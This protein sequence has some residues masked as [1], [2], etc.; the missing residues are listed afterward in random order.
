M[1]GADIGAG[2][3]SEAQGQALIALAR[4]TISR[5]LGRLVPAAVDPLLAAPALQVQSGT[6]VTLKLHGQLRGCIGSLLATGSIVE[7]V[8]ENAI[9][10]AFEDPR[11]PPLT[12]EE[13]DAV[14]IEVSVLTE[15]QPLEYQDAADLLTRL[16]PGRD[17]LIIRKG[18]CSATFLPQVWEQLP[19]PHQFLTHLCLK[20]GLAA[21]A[22]Q[23]E[24]LAVLTYQVRYFEEQR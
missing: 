18:V 24:H 8:R 4:Q 7:G 20:A 10:A 3:I 14:A 6:F 9:N 19:D 11:F 5:H 2:T 13:L 23:R 15:P 17:G 22:W 21:D 16:R 1:T 12:V